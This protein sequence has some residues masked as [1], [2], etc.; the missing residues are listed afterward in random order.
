[1]RQPLQKAP[2][3]TPLYAADQP[4]EFSIP[5][6]QW[7]NRIIQLFAQSF[8]TEVTITSDYTAQPG[9]V[10]FVYTTAGNVAV[11]LPSAAGSQN[12][13]IT[14]TKVSN[15]ANQLLVVPAGTDLVQGAQSQTVTAQW[16][17]LRY[18][19]DGAGNWFPV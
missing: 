12:G 7:W 13:E 14:I 5:W 8:R 15:D 10:I 6:I 17:V 4:K 11:S 18:G 19:S 1:M 9:D 2:I 3:E 16:T